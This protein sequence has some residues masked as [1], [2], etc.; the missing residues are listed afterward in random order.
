MLI[1]FV[2]DS[3]HYMAQACTCLCHH[4]WWLQWICWIQF[5]VLLNTKSRS[6]QKRSPQPTTYADTEET[7]SN[8]ACTSKNNAIITQNNNIIY[9]IFELCCCSNATFS[10]SIGSD[11]TTKL[12]KLAQNTNTTKQESNEHIQSAANNNW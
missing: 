3:R 5:N 7:K 11:L 8:T 2:L 4:H 6:F 1:L 12:K 9:L 10:K